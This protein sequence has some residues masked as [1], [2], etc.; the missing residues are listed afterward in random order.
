MLGLYLFLLGLRGYS[1]STRW[2]K[3]L[4]GRRDAYCSILHYFGC[5]LVSPACGL[6]ITVFSWPL[7]DGVAVATAFVEH[8]RIRR[9]S[10]MEYHLRGYSKLF[11]MQVRQARRES[12]YGTGSVIFLDFGFWRRF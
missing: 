5:F 6:S 10:A 7:V 9:E 12:C 1:C 4:A 3:Q 8:S 11:R 2:R